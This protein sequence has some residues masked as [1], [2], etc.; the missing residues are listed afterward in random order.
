MLHIKSSRDRSKLRKAGSKQLGITATH[1]LNKDTDECKSP[2][3][4]AKAKDLDTGKKSIG[5]EIE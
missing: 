5:D 4:I 1:D 2:R 3:V